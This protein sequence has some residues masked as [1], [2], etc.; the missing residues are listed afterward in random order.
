M[1]EIFKILERKNKNKNDGCNKL[2]KLWKT[3]LY[4]W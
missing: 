2:W 1:N 4:R 3:L